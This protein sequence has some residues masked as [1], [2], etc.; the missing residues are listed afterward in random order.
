MSK[1]TFTLEQIQ[2]LRATQYIKN[3]SEKSIIYSYEFK[4]YFVSKSLNSKTAKQI[5]IAAGFD[6]EMI[7][8]SRIKA[9]TTKMRKRYRDNRILSLEDTRKNFSG[10]PR[11]TELT[12][13]QQIEKLQSK[14]SIL[15]QKNDIGKLMK[16]IEMQKKIMLA[17]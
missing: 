4:R 3:V 15:E 12:P 9:F 8:E 13:E 6:P 2:I 7:G 10:S 5:F 16:I 1:L 17:N 11:K 14:I